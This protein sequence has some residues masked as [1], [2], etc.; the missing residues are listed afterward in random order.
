MIAMLL[1]KAPHAPAAVTAAVIGVS[2]PGVGYLFHTTAPAV[3]IVVGVAL[4]AGRL[5]PGSNYPFSWC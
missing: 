1:L 3:A 5:L 4:L 2:D